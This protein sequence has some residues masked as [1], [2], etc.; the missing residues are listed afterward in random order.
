MLISCINADNVDGDTA[1]SYLRIVSWSRNA[2][3]L[4]DVEDTDEKTWFEL[5]L[6]T[7][8]IEIMLGSFVSNRLSILLLFSYANFDGWGGLLMLIC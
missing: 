3:E 5:L 8:N 2:A 1:R 6:V 4:V 7:A